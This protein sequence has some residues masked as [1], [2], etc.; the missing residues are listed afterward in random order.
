MLE[1]SFIFLNG[2]GET[3]E[4]RLWDDGIANWRQFLETSTALGIGSA[5]K[6]LYDREVEQTSEDFQRAH[7]RTVARRFKA[8]YHWRLFQ[9]FRARTVF[10]D[11]ETN[12]YPAGVGEITM[13]GLYG[14]HTMTTLVRH[15]NL[16]LDRLQDE[17]SKYDLIVT[18]FGSGFDLPYL[19]MSYPRL[20]LSHGHFDLCFA[21]RRLGL[22]GGLKHIETEL[23]LARSD[24]LQGLD[25]WDAVNLWHAWQA[26]D[27]RAGR[28]LLEYNEADVRNLE[29][30]ADYLYQALR[31]RHGPGGN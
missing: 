20:D 8:A 2:I 7:W 12:G 14:H 31:A 5:R 1:S 27:E 26:G 10:L 29:P 28:I 16:T 19:R 23:G 24:D 15:R 13:V 30:L 21:A 11:I 9:A 4:R 22:R 17:L 18:F 25:G 3:T 6:A